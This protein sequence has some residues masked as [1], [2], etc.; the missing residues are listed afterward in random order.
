MFVVAVCKPLKAGGPSSLMIRQ[1]KSWRTIAVDSEIA[2]PK[3]QE[4][5][6]CLRNRFHTQNLDP[7]MIK[8]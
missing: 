3:M 1:F 2:K 8:N 4:S 7:I 5:D 6:F